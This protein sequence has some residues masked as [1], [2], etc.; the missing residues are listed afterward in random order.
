[1]GVDIGT[2]RARIDEFVLGNKLE[3]GV[4]KKRQEGCAAEVL[5]V[6]L[7]IV[8]LLVIGGVE[9]NPGPQIEQVKIN[10]ILACVKNQEKESKVIKQMFESHKQEMSEMRKRTD[11]L[12]PNFD[13][14]SEIVTEMIND[15]GHIKQ[16]IRECA[17]RYQ[18]LENK[19]RYVHE[20]QRKTK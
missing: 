15:Y 2:Y 4:L 17:A 12:G 13:R 14:L 19:L 16:A 18:R 10:Q 1:M 11:A 8:I 7:V 3:S 20:G 9:T 5:F 6:G